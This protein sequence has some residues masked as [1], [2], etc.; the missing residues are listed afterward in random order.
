MKSASM[1]F[2]V[3]A[4]GL[5]MACGGEPQAPVEEP[6][7]PSVAE[8][9]AVEGESGQ[10]SA[11]ACVQLYRP[12]HSAWYTSYPISEDGLVG[13]CTTNDDCTT[14]C[15]GTETPYYTHTVFFY[16]TYCP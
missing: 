4:A 13:S 15:W 6:S 14:D 10:V 7:A 2:A 11:Q 3:L 1:G 12:R 8:G 16:C 5:L 9:A